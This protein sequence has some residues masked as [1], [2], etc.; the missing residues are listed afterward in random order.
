MSASFPD[1]G[2]SNQA[3]AFRRRFAAA[4]GLGRISGPEGTE[5]PQP[6]DPGIAEDRLIGPDPLPA[7]AVSWTVAEPEE[8]DVP[9]ELGF[10]P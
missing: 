1:G 7:T 10:E 6:A 9:D 4:T 2:W 8:L 3:S 5:V